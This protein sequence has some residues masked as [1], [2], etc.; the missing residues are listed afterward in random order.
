MRPRTLS[1][2]V[3]VNTGLEGHGPNQGEGRAKIQLLSEG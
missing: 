2:L 1:Q 3:A